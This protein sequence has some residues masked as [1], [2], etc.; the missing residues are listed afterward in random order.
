MKKK[1][2]N[3]KLNK[4]NIDFIYIVIKISKYQT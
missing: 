3:E 1:F 4:K 2:L